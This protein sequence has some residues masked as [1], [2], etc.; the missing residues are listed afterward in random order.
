MRGEYGEDQQEPFTIEGLSPR[1]RG[2]R[3]PP[4]RQNRSKRSIPA[5]A[6]NTY[7]RDPA[8][9]THILYPRVRGEYMGMR[10]G[11]AGPIRSIPACAGNTTQKQSVKSTREVYPR[12]R[13]E[14]DS[15]LRVGFRGPGLSPRA[16][17]ILAGRLRHTR[18]LGSIPACAGN[19]GGNHAGLNS[20]GR[21][22]PACA[23]NT[24]RFPP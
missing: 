3:F 23:G 11:A 17:G 12:V 19:T 2:I 21:S 13:G 4:A 16:R 1:A 8:R 9:T 15:G 6:G 5:C 24:I 14:Y 22:I 18:P 20:V 10:R 7:F